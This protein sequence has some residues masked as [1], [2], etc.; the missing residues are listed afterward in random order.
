L[1]VSLILLLLIAPKNN[2]SK[3]DFPFSFTKIHAIDRAHSQTN[4]EDM[5]VKD[6]K[7]ELAAR[8]IDVFDCREKVR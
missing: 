2:K 7:R 1:I 8:G 6:L 4:P 5:G 3:Q